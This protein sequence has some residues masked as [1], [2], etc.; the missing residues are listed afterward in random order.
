[1]NLSKLQQLDKKLTI[2]KNRVIGTLGENLAVNDL[3]ENGFKV[4]RTGAGSDFE[5]IKKIG[6]KT[7]R[8]LVEVKT[9]NA[10]LTKKQKFLKRKAKK[11][12]IDFVEYR[13]SNQYL[14]H[15]IVNSPTLRLMLS[16]LGYDL[17][18]F[19]GKFIIKNPAQCPNCFTSAAGINSILKNFGLRNMGDGTVKVQS[20]CRDC[21][22]KTRRRNL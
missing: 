22:N 9:G 12:K 21:R 8:K 14:Q 6:S 15:Q 3:M 16:N 17:N 13:I 7:I 11:G 1:M 4:T 19:R 10:R 5:A 18:K 20:W 2:H